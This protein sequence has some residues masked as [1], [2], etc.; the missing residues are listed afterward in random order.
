MI[1]VRL[2]FSKIEIIYIIDVVDVF[3]LILFYC[4]IKDFF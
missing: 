1:Y 4:Y 2:F 3:V